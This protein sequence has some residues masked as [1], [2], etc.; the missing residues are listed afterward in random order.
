MNQRFETD[1]VEL[2]RVALFSGCI[3]GRNRLLGRDECHPE[4]AHVERI[5]LANRSMRGVK[6]LL[7]C[8]IAGA[9]LKKYCLAENHPKEKEAFSLVP[10]PVTRSRAMSA[11]TAVA[12][13]SAPIF[14]SFAATKAAYP[15]STLG[16]PNLFHWV[17]PSFPLG[18]PKFCLG[19]PIIK[20]SFCRKSPTASLSLLKLCDLD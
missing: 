12:R 9:N 5:N 2:A 16:S 19:H 20:I 6:D 17:T 13:G 3:S 8:P 14:T 10:V 11:I 15:I 4:P 18:H 1:T 7:C